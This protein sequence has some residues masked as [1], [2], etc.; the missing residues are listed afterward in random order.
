M[1]EKTTIDMVGYKLF[2]FGQTWEFHFSHGIF[3]GSLDEVVRYA[4]LRHDFS[5][6]ELEI[7]VVEIEKGFHDG[8]EFG[9]YKSFMFPIDLPS[10]T[11]TIH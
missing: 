7:G 6:S 11:V 8:A 4:V 10:N 3:R 5:V 2:D 9:I 1:V